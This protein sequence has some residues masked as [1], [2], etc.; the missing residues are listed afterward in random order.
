MAAQLAEAEGCGAAL[1][2]LRRLDP[3]HR[4]ARVVGDNLAVLQFG[5]GLGRLWRP[6]MHSAMSG[7]LAALLADCPVRAPGTVADVVLLLVTLLCVEQTL[8]IVRRDT[9]DRR[10]PARRR[11]VIAEAA[12]AGRGRLLLARVEAEALG[13]LL[14][15]LPHIPAGPDPLHPQGCPFVCPKEQ[16]AAFLRFCR[17]QRALQNDQAMPIELQSL[18]RRCTHPDT[19]W[20]SNNSRSGR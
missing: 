15:G 7:P 9:P 5:A 10:P 13:P 6:A 20:R 16:G 8:E 2:L 4:A 19:L 14:R 1:R 12:D 3:M 17:Q 18:W 11:R